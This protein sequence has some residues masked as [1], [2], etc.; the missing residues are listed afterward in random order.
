MADG[1]GKLVGIDLGTT[2]CAL[3]WV[4]LQASDG[5][6]TV[7]GS[8][9]IPQLTAPGAVEERSLLPSFLY[10]PHAEELAPGDMALPWSSE[11]DFIV[12][13]LA[14]SRGATT[15][16]SGRSSANATNRSTASPTTH[17]SELM[18]STYLPLATRIPAFS[19]AP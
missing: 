14:R 8:M 15:P 16:T 18:I 3:S 1:T 7:Q 12:G 5:E 6:K 4:D 19:P 9:A 11:Q 13:D 2:H 10:L 17:A